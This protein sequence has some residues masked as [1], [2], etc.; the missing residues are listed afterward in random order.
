MKIING[1]TIDDVRLGQAGILFEPDDKIEDVKEFLE[2]LESN[3]KQMITWPSGKAT[4]C[5]SV[6]GGSNPSVIF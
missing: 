5:N 1:K 2:N 3:K 6:I 4:D